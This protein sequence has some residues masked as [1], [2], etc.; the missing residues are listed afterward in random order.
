[1]YDVQDVYWMFNERNEGERGGGGVSTHEY[2][3]VDV[4]TKY[5]INIGSIL[6][7]TYP[8]SKACKKQWWVDQTDETT[9]KGCNMLL[10]QLEARIPLAHARNITSLRHQSRVTANFAG[11]P[12]SL[13]DS[14]YCRSLSMTINI[15]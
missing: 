9:N 1:M 10:N 13:C 5:E 12:C 2:E 3:K 15:E 8:I 11:N 14:L 4:Q 6:S 7:G